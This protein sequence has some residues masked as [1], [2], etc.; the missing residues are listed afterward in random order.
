VKVSEIGE[1]GLIKLLAD[2]IKKTGSAG[3]GKCHVIA[4]I[5]DDAA[6]WSCDNAVQIATTDTLIEDIHFDFNFTGW[7]EI[8]YKAIAVNLSDIAAMGGTPL[9]MLVSLAIPGYTDVECILNAYHGMFQIA[10][11]FGVI[12]IGGNIA[13]SDK[14]TINVTALGS[15]NSETALLRST[16]KPGD[17]IAIT[18]YTGISAAGLW[19]MK[20]RQCFGPETERAFRKAHLQPFPRIDE[21]KI[22]RELG[23]KTAIDISD[24]LLADLSHICDAS[25]VKATVKKDL[26]PV[27]PLLKSCFSED[28]YTQFILTGG[29]DYELLFTAPG[30]IIELVKEKISCP[31]TTIGEITGGAPGQVDVVDNANETNGLKSM[32]WDHF[33]HE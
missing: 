28:K 22:L 21:G 19:M 20:E 5:G 25:Q 7:E 10:N 16:A 15:L 8:G 1:F 24:G 13:A 6:I 11:R 2:E 17:H 18:G 27:H 23:V 3:T 30:S 14:V 29:E 33:S 26:V 9:Y 12:I 31:V 4:G 32:G